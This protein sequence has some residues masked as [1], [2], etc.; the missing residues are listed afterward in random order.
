MRCVGTFNRHELYNLLCDN[1]SWREKYPHCHC[2]IG[3]DRDSVNAFLTIINSFVSNRALSR[4]DLT[5]FTA[6]K[7]TY[8]NEALYGPSISDN[9]L[10][11]ATCVSLTSLITIPIYLITYLYILFVNRLLLSQPESLSTRTKNLI[12]KFVRNVFVASQRLVVVL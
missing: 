5:F 7:D 4:Y 3:D 8:I 9:F 6:T 12:A 1:W 2:I 10:I 11:A